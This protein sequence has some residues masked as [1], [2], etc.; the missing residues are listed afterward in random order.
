MDGTR[1]DTCPKCHAGSLLREPLYDRC[2]MCG[3]LT[4]VSRSFKAQSEYERKSGLARL[5]MSAGE[6]TRR[7]Y[8]VSYRKAA[9]EY[10][11]GVRADAPAAP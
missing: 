2:R 5:E 4:V 10:E 1:S 7:H 6:D 8:R 9:V 11:A 3:T